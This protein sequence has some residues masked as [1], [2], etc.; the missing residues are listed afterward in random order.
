MAAT[1]V[2]GVGPGSADKQQKGSEHLRVGVEKLIGPKA[3]AVGQVT[4]SGGTATL[5]LP[6]LPGVAG[7]YVVL[8]NDTTA[9]AAVKTVLAITAT[10]TTVTFTGTG[11][12]VI[13]Y[14]VFHVGMAISMDQKFNTLSFGIP[15]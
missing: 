5:D 14:G 4:L 1:S 12:D 15:A 8:A 2:T 11:S 3:I 10:G 9:A 13:S 7:N 6:V